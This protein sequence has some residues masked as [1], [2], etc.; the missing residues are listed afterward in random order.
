MA[1]KKSSKKLGIKATRAALI[2]F[3][4]LLASFTIVYAA[5]YNINT[6]DN[7]ASDWTPVGVFQTD[8]TGDFVASPDGLQSANDDIIEARVAT[9][10]AGGSTGTDLYFYLKVAGTNAV[11]EQY[12]V[13]VAYIDCDADG[14]QNGPYD[15][16]E[17]TDRMIIYRPTADDVY[18]CEGVPP[19]YG[20]SQSCFVIPDASAITQEYGERPADALNVIEWRMPIN[21]LPPDDYDPQGDC[22][23]TVKIQFFT[24]YNNPNKPKDWTIIDRIDVG[25]G[26]FGPP[27]RLYNAP[28][29]VTLEGL[30]AR[31]QASAFTATPAALAALSIA[32]I[33]LVS[34]WLLVKNFKS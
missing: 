30:S 28:T 33:A 17:Q 14:P 8:P 21:M 4:A 7:T 23:G 25:D 13:P 27:Y 19:G 10:P 16:W 26:T 32:I 18:D 1:L 15:E 12:H 11:S 29:V 6:N 9:G 2:I 31:S 3:I 5:T 24:A 20:V 22:R 34:S